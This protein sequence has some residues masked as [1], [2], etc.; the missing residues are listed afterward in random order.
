[1]GKYVYDFKLHCEKTK[2]CE[3]LLLT[4]PGSIWCALHRLC[5][6]IMWLCETH[7]SHWN[8]LEAFHTK[9]WILSNFS[10]WE[11]HEWT[12]PSHVFRLKPIRSNLLLFYCHT[13]KTPLERSFKT[14]S[15]TGFFGT[16]TESH[17]SQETES[18]SLAIRF[19]LCSV[20]GKRYDVICSLFTW[21][22]FYLPPQCSASRLLFLCLY[23]PSS[24]SFPTLASSLPLPVQ[25]AQTGAQ[26]IS[27]MGALPSAYTEILLYVVGFFVFW[28]LSPLI[29][30]ILHPSLWH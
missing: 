5:C 12:K 3:Y 20:H 2:K 17:T 7:S 22:Y 15:I 14:Y 24:L 16:A 9:L 10:T 4:D 6:K 29:L 1:M 27:V 21:P 26:I 8:E 28:V 25:W 11:K 13:S 18:F 23:C 30:L 19:K